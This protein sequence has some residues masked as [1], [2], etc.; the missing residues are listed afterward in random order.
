M[1][2]YHSDPGLTVMRKIERLRCKSDGWIVSYWSK[3]YGNRSERDVSSFRP[4]W[5]VDLTEQRA[6]TEPAFGRNLRRKVPVPD[7]HVFCVV[8]HQLLSYKSAWKGYGDFIFISFV[9]YTEEWGQSYSLMASARNLPGE[10]KGK[11]C[12][13]T[14]KISLISWKLSSNAAFY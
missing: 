13:K 9:T 2:A 1:L 12:V 3:R 8:A 4:Q 7:L 11:A 10:K 5:T 14:K 6:T